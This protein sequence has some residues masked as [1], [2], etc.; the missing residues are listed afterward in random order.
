MWFIF[1]SA[2]SQIEDQLAALA[3]RWA[4]IC[5]WAEERGGKL[6]IVS[7]KT[8]DLEHNLA[9]L[10]AW[11]NQQKVMLKNMESQPT[12][13]IGEILERIKKLQ[14]TDSILHI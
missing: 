5:Q 9:T 1:F 8:F 6:Q 13:E 3:E 7:N 10:E 14:V 12:S 4:H 2:Q 11:I